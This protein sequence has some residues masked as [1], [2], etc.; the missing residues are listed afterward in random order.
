MN[1]A[2]KTKS[3]TVTKE[4]QQQRSRETRAKILHAASECLARLG[5]AELSTMRVAEQAGVSKGALFQHF[6][7]KNALIVATVEQYHED[8]RQKSL[9]LLADL[10]PDVPLKERLRMFVS[11]CWECMKTP[12]F[13]SNN[14]VW[15]AART[16]PELKQALGPLIER[17]QGIVDIERVL[18]EFP[19]SKITAILNNLVTS[20]IE[21]M[22]MDYHVLG[23][24][25]SLELQED[26][27]EY[28]I[29]FSVRE[30]EHLKSGGKL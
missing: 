10:T 1:K 21:G 12:E 20:T 22:A 29:E 30:L 2:T 18:P 23:D 19:K 14:D 28:L 8:I 15:A 27:L 25:E 4:P 16:N 6:P 11:S 24:S 3:T 26:T 13:I 17:E 9:T 7:T 5:Y